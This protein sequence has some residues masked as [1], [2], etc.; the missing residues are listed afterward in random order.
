MRIGLAYNQRPDDVTWRGGGDGRVSSREPSEP[1]DAFVEWDDPETIEAVGNALGI[2]GDVVPLEAVDDFPTRL[3]DARVDFLFNMAEGVSGP[4][5]ESHVP[6]IAE[7][8]GIPYLGSDPLTLALALHKGRAKETF[9]Q[10]G[11]PTPGFLLIET[12]ADVASLNG[13][14]RYPLFLK[15]VW[16]GSSKGIG[17]ANHAPTLEVARE[18]SRELL[19]TYRQPVLAE[20]YLPG[21]EFTAAILGNGSDAEVLPLI[22]YRFGALP[23]GALP[24]MGYEA[25]WLWDQPDSS[26]DVLECPAQVPDGL[27]DRIR[28]TALAAYHALG[29]RDWSRVDLRL[30]ADGLPYVLEVNPLPGVMPDPG[31]HSCFPCAASVAGMSYDELIQAVTRI[32]WRRATGKELPAPTL[33][34]ASR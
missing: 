1:A 19:A 18:R 25:K 8:F 27:A 33:A 13:A 3:R 28:A 17:E 20:S 34:G 14:M 22:R 10:R 31:A 16:E 30:D 5:R 29:C 6:A 24:I 15:P 2:F 32:A 21:D 12:E 7:F 23:D 26:L 4:S 9:V 11:V